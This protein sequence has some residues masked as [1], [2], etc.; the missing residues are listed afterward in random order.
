MATRAAEPEPGTLVERPVAD[1]RLGDSRGDC[2]RGLHDRARGSPAAVW[3]SR[4]ERQ[5]LNADIAGDFD[6]LVVI[7][8][9]GDHAVNV[10]R[11]QSSV[12]DGGLD[13]FT[14]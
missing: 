10:G 8:G 2:H 4:E 12:V 13:R 14:G 3:D 5:V 9:K 7:D 1:H 6:F 11:P